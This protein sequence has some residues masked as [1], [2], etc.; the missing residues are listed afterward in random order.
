MNLFQIFYISLKLYES[1]YF[2]SEIPMYYV[3][4]DKVECFDFI[5][6][7]YSVVMMCRKNVFLTH[8]VKQSGFDG[9]CQV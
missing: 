2:P 1:P 9:S 3:N 4:T 7:M 5:Y 8:L 6:F